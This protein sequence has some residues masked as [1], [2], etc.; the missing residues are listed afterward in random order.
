MPVIQIIFPQAALHF[1]HQPGTVE[2]LTVLAL[3][4]KP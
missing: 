3:S 1:P 2:Q 4:H